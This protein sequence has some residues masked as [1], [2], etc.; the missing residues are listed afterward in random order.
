M[1]EYTH[2]TLSLHL[3]V[4]VFYEGGGHNEPPKAYGAP[5]SLDFIGLKWSCGPK[6]LSAREPK[7]PCSKT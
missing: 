4:N 1:E 3:D 5:K 2:P 7:G 6:N